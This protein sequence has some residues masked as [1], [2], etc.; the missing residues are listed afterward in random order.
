MRLIAEIISSHCLMQIDQLRQLWP[1]ILPEH[2]SFI[3]PLYIKMRTLFIVS[4]P[5]YSMNAYCAREQIL[6]CISQYCDVNN[7]VIHN[8]L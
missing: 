4:I 6:A 1:S 8:R 7:I 3:Q 5:G 2:A